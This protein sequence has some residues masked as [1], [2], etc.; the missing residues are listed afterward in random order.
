MDGQQIAALLPYRIEVVAG[1]HCV[2]K[3]LA[4]GLVCRTKS[5]GLRVPSGEGISRIFR[6]AKASISRQRDRAVIRHVCCR[7]SLVRR[8][9]AVVG[10]PDSLRRLPIDRR[11]RHIAGH[12]QFSAGIAARAVS[13]CTPVQEDLALRRCY[14]CRWQ[15]N[16][17]CASCI[18]VGIDRC[19][20][21]AITK[22]IRYRK[23]LCIACFGIELIVPMDLRT[24]VERHMV[25]HVH[26]AE[27]CVTCTKRDLR[28]LVFRDGP[29]HR[30]VKRLEDLCPIN[31]I[32]R[33]RV[34]LW[35]PFGVE[36]EIVGRHLLTGEDIG[37]ALAF[38][39]VKPAAKCIVLHIGRSGR[40]ITGI[41]NRLLIFSDQFFLLAAVIHED[42]L[43]AVAVIIEFCTVVP[44]SIFG[45][46]CRIADK[47][48]DRIAVFIRDCRATGSTSV[49]MVQH[50][51]T[52]K[53]LQVVV[54]FRASL[55]GFEELIALQRHSA[56]T[57]LECRAARLG[58]PDSSRPLFTDVCAV[59]G[60]NAN[61]VDLLV[62]DILSGKQ[63]S[64][65]LNREELHGIHIPLI[66]DIDDG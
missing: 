60:G 47:A 62:L 40:R 8:K 4:A 55:T 61:G 41:G 64:F 34:G 18:L 53:T 22:V 49:R 13:R 3:H 10:Y 9:I 54:R 43:V 2:H 12:G 42:D 59:L 23:L 32:H 24:E 16:S 21:R 17:L 20:A 29:A 1:I 11:Q 26:P 31:V 28:H 19:L 45:A 63:P 52:C 57:C 36:C 7:V 44:R 66:I 56:N 37:A 15:N 65:I 30:N 58:G 14:A 35:D 33:H 38:F 39:V 5:I 51:V 48:G 27:K 25:L 50:I 46:L 6:K